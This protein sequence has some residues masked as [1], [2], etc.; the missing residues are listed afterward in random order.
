MAIGVESS[1]Q[2]GDEAVRAGGAEQV[3][4]Q[5]A[6]LL[7]DPR[8]GC[9]AEPPR[10]GHQPPDPGTTRHSDAD[11]QLNAARAHLFDP[12]DDRFGIEAELRDDVAAPAS[13]AAL[14]SSAA[15]SI[16]RGMPKCP[17]GYP[18]MLTVFTPNSSRAAVLISAGAFS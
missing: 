9:D 16:C 5:E 7:S 4:Q 13:A 17:S 1:R 2:F 3:G 11:R 14:C 18:L 12:A 15:H 10:E 8:A 6:V